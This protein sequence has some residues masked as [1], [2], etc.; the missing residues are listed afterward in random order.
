MSE[1][2]ILIYRSFERRVDLITEKNGGHIEFCVNLFA[3]RLFFLN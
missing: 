3:L 2:F 1:E